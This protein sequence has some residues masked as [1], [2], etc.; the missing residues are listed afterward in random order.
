[1]GC[2]SLTGSG[3]DDLEATEVRGLT[4]LPFMAGEKK[5]KKEREKAESEGPWVPI[6][7]RLTLGCPNM[8]LAK[9]SNSEMNVSKGFNR[10]LRDRGWGLSPHF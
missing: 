1:M 9:E 3:W 7:G 5:E 2:Y 10:S 4:E 6:A 8:I